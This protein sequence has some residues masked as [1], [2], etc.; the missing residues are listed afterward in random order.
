MLGWSGW[1]DAESILQ[2]LFFYAKEK[3]L[4]LAYRDVSIATL[5]IDKKSKG[6]EIRGKN[7]S[8]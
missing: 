8:K 7:P 4:E 1:G 5:K 6:K 3:G 2:L